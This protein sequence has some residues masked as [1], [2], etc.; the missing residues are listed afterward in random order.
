MIQQSHNAAVQPNQLVNREV[1]LLEFQRRVLQEAMEESNP[2]LER[3]KFLSIFYS[4]MDEYFMVRIAGIRR[5]VEAH[6]V[7]VFPDGLNPS[8]VLESARAISLELYEMAGQMLDKRVRPRL[9]KAGIFLMDYAA[10]NPMQKKQLADYFREVIYPRLSPLAFDPGHPFPHRAGMNLNLAVVVKDENGQNKFACIQ[11]PET[12]PRFIPL[13]GSRGTPANGTVPLIHTFVP[14][15]QVITVHLG[16]LF[17]GV[18]VQ[19]AY[20]FRLLRDADLPLQPSE[21][22]DLLQAMQQRVYRTRFAQVVQLTVPPDMPVD[23][24]NLLLK[25]LNL[26][27]RDLYILTSALGLES[28]FQLFA[29]VDRPDLKYPVYIPFIPEA[30]RQPEESETIFRAI[31]EKNIL[32]HRPYDSFQPIVEFLF[33]A[34]RDPQVLSIKQTIYRLEDHA[35][36]IEALQEASR[37]GKEVIVLV[38]LQARFDE[39]SNISW[40]RALERAGVHVVYGV[41]G[42]K[43]HCKVI[44]VVRQEENELRRYMHFSTGNYNAVTSGTYEDIGMFTSDPAIGEDATDLFNYL[45]GYSHKNQYQKIYVSPLN[46][47]QNLEAMIRREIEIA[48]RGGRA[49]LMFKANALVDLELI[50]LL[51]EAS[52]AGVQVD[53]MIRGICC[54]LPGVKGLSENIRVVSVIGRFLEHSRIYYFYNNGNEQIYLSSADLMPRNLDYRVE[55][56]FPVTDP[57]HLRYL[58]EDVLENYLRDDTHAHRMQPDGSYECLRPSREN[59]FGVQEYLTSIAT[60]REH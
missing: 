15:E 28:L 26:K 55:V 2:L 18:D 53:L 41:P 38:E 6:V 37:R 1:S 8:Q 20:P 40:A 36:V 58:R 11:I 19:G 47:R 48:R 10:L 42:L 57:E 21:G 17:P 3:I 5:Q 45:T 39:V 33:A 7:D 43:T 14:L 60:K 27:Q 24:R 44:M 22:D 30:F 12:L 13:E 49:R 46:L 34:A 35:I 29:T 23:V 50:K 59:P 31:R 25:Q 4:N 52:Q 54:L 51:Y 16:S 56:M 32:I 9:E